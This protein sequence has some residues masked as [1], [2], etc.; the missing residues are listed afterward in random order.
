M[1][2][3]RANGPLT[4]TILPVVALDDVY[5][6]MAFG[7]AMS[8]AKLSLSSENVSVFQMFSAPFIEIG[9]SLLLG[10]I[11]GVILAFLSKKVAHSRDEMQI[12]SLTAIGIATGLS[13]VLGFS[14]IL[15]NIAMGTVVVNVV[16]NSQRIF[17]AVNDFTPVFYVLFFT[18]AG[19]SLDLSILGAVGIMGVAYIICRA[20]GKMIGAW[21]GCKVMKSPKLVTKWLGLGLLPQGGISIGL[22]VL[23]RQELP[24][25]A[26]AITTI[27][28]FSV[29]VY[30]T[31]G[32]I[33]AKIAISKAGEINGIDRVQE[34]DAP[35]ETAAPAVITPE[36]VPQ[37]E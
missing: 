31:T 33:F 13:K 4:R 10:S 3:Y 12:I 29:L 24:Q 25:Y 15:T 11:L 35:A 16:R 9:G 8:L 36:L 5:G 7:I 6:I 18:L 32:P 20:S 28:M 22:S 19:A 27:I 2:Q 21:F 14:S 30:E 26:V 17:G 23:V 1:K 37:P 34:T